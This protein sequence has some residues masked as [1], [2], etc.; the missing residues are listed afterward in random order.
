MHK[1]ILEY[2]KDEFTPLSMYTTSQIEK[3]KIQN[4][5]RK[6]KRAKT[7]QKGKNNKPNTD[8]G[9]HDSQLPSQH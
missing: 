7:K 9:N 4:R 1:N 8:S 3:N 2:T 5:L 6:Q